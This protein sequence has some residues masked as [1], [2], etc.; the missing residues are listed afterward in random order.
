MLQI[1]GAEAVPFRVAIQVIP[2]VV[3]GPAFRAAIRAAPTRLVTAAVGEPIELDVALVRG[4][5]TL[6]LSLSTPSAT[7]TTADISRVSVGP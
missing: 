4:Q 1:R 6:A 7:G 2:D 5:T 3:G